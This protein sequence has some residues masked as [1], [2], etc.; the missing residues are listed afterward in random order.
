MSQSVVVLRKAVFRRAADRLGSP[1]FRRPLDL[2]IEPTHRWAVT[3]PRKTELLEVL[4]SKHIADPADGRSYPYLHQSVWPSQV[5]QLIEF[6]NAAIKAPHLSARYE[7]FRDEFDYTLR[8]VLKQTTQDEGEISRVLEELAL[9]GI[10]D[11]W[12]VGL[13][14]GQNRRAR[15][16]TALLKHPRLLLID[17]PFLGLDP[18]SRRLVAEVM[19]RLPPNPHVV[20]GLRYQDSFPSWITHVAVTDADGIAHQGPRADMMP[21]VEELRDRAHERAAKA[22]IAMQDRHAAANAANSAA[23]TPPVIHLDSVSVSYRGEP[24]LRDLSWTVRRNERWHL[25]GDNGAGKSTLLAMLTADHP[26]SWNPRVSVFGEPRQVGKQSYFSVNERIGHCSPEIHSIFPLH[27]TVAK[28]VSSGYT[29]GSF[30]APS[31]LPADK[32]AHVQALIDEFGLDPNAVLADLTLSDQKTVMFLRAIVKSPDLLI[33]DEAFSAMTE[34]RV[35]QCRA[36]VDSGSWTVIAVGHIH[37]E[38]PTVDKFLR[39]A[40]KA[41]PAE[42]GLVQPEH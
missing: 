7:S 31:N 32:S 10:E 30:L 37:Q 40:P 17:E 16:A 2:A 18:A 39:L 38:L 8:E 9:K 6:S 27:Y 13:S 22:R 3:G 21:I 1:I 28:A 5:T 26:Q 20:L 41:G 36:K 33:L 11:R 25:R 14:N 12:F 4:A 23:N 29:V 19:G 35:A 42:I 24:V 15:L 34:D